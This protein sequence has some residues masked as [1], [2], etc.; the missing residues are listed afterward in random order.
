MS[1]KKHDNPK[2]SA[3]EAQPAVPQAGQ[4]EQPSEKRDDVSKAR[5]WTFWGV[6]AGTVM[7]ARA[8]DALMPNTPE[9]VIE[10]W[11]MLAFGIFMAVFLT[12]L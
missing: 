4:P 5:F 10:R 8:L 12:R 3:P 11:I 6:L 1:K 9:H 2:D 7:V